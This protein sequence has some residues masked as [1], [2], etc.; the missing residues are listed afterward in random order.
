MR[1]RVLLPHIPDRQTSHQR[2]ANHET[3]EGNAKVAEASFVI[4]VQ[5]TC[6]WIAADWIAAD[7]KFSSPHV[8]PWRRVISLT[9]LLTQSETVVEVMGSLQ[10]KTTK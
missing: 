9:A 1:K 3:P 5:V 4:R 8:L 10:E 7:R 6:G 2:I